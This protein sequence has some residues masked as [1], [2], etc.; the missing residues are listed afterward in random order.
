MKIAIINLTGGGMSGGYIKYLSNVIP[1][2]AVHPNVE[3]ILCASPK[4]L[5]VHDWFKPLSNVESVNCKPFRF[6]RQ[7]SDQELKQHLEEFSPDVIYS[8]T[9]RSFQFNKV[10]IVKMVQNMEPRWN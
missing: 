7:G 2:M 1:R 10:P 9:E 8:P 3:A 4:S 6:M 5:N